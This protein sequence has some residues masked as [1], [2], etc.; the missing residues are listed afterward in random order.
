MKCECVIIKIS[1]VFCLIIGG[2]DMPFGNQE[3][4]KQLAMFL[5][6]ERIKQKLTLEDIASKTGVPYQH[7]KTIEDAKFDKFDEF[8]VKMYVKKYAMTLNLDADELLQQFGA[9]RSHYAQRPNKHKKTAI[10]DN[11]AKNKTRLALVL[12][13]LL[14]SGV[15]I[16]VIGSGSLS[17]APEVEE[18]VPPVVENKDSEELLTQTKPPVEETVEDNKEPE[19]LEEVIPEPPVVE[20]TATVESSVPQS[21]VFNLQTSDEG[22]KLNMTFTEDCWVDIKLGSE[23]L[24]AGTV[25]SADKSVEL[26]ITKEMVSKANELVL[27]VGNVGVTTIK[28]NDTVVKS[29]QETPHQYL[30]LKLNF[31]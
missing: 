30:T 7:L 1:C 27:N 25:Y 3:K 8:Y 28:L 6:E 21:S 4:N 11:R 2:V 24:D 15:G 12:A 20:T 16:A 23:V 9:V 29:S 5:Q 26:M 17:P 31:K 13:I 14:I 18:E 10:A 22:Y 19:V